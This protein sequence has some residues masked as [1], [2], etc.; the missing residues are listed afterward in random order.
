[1][2]ARKENVPHSSKDAESEALP[3]L[4]TDTLVAQ[5]RREA[6]ASSERIYQ[7]VMRGG[8]EPYGSMHVSGI[9]TLTEK[10]VRFLKQK[11]FFSFLTFEKPKTLQKPNKYTRYGAAPYV[12]DYPT[13][14]T[15]ASQTRDKTKGVPK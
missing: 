9:H 3:E 6:Q 5:K 8:G 14:Q 15:P 10:I 1:M 7:S 11:G 4:S 2:V 13:S 12:G